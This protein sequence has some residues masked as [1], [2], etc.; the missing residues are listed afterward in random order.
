M[1]S[2]MYRCVYG[3]IYPRM[4]Q[5]PL[6]QRVIEL[7]EHFRAI[8]S[9]ICHG[10]RCSCCVVQLVEMALGIWSFCSAMWSFSSCSWLH[11]MY[12]T[13]L[14]CRETIRHWDMCKTA[15]ETFR[16]VEIQELF[17]LRYTALK[18]SNKLFYDCVCAKCLHWHNNVNKIGL[19][20]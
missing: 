4:L 9:T 7:M 2:I 10:Y 20:C 12:N 18:E 15:R 17:G 3:I 14:V 11:W 19:W 8:H 16:C 5:R 1:L 6:M 13:L